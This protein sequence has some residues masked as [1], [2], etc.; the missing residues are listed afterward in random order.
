VIPNFRSRQTSRFSASRLAFALGLLAAAALLAQN[1]TPDKAPAK[2]AIAWQEGPVRARLGDQATLSVPRG[3][4]FADEANARLFLERTQNIPDGKEL[5]ILAS[6]GGSWFA[7]FEFDPVGY[8]K[9]DE[10]SSLDGN[11]IL[12]TIKKANEEGNIERKRRGWGT[13]TVTGWIDPPHYDSVTHQLSWA[14]VGEDEK[15]EKTANYRTRLLGRRGVMSVELVVSPARLDAV[16]P[17]FKS[18]AIDGFTFLAANNYSSYVPGDK[19]AEYGLTALI[20]GGAAAAAVK[21]GLFKY[22]GKL[23]IVGWKFVVIAFGA[24]AGAVKKFFASFTRKK[25]TEPNPEPDP[26]SVAGE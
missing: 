11:A 5:G 2:P 22:L 14:L 15:S 4:V 9:D 3:Y 19:V 8:V 6:N 12:D 10:K 16:L 23:L 18:S 25:K 24:M 20:V 1:N 7:I 17:V 21:T 26:G 13:F